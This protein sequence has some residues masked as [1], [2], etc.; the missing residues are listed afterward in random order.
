MG[1][2]GIGV[3]EHE[4]ADDVV[5]RFEDWCKADNSAQ[6]AASPDAG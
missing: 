6:E 2:W 3:W 1:A 5:L 4:V